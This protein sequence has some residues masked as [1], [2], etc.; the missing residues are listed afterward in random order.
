MAQLALGWLLLRR[1]NRA[2]LV[3]SALGSIAV[4][5][6]WVATRTMRLPLLN[7]TPE[8]VG[9][10]DVAASV[11]ELVFAAGVLAALMRPALVRFSAF[12]WGLSAALA[13][14]PLAHAAHGAAAANVGVHTVAHAGLIAGACGAFG[15]VLVRE[16][17]AG[18]LGFSM[19]LHER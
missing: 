17:R 11:L 9:L 2:P 4:V 18:R 7:E 6:A 1:A 5:A 3:W 14:T 10:P 13:T 16:A 15:H 8:P 12:A 19:S